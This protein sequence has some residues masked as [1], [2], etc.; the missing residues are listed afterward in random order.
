MIH[1]RTWL[2]MGTALAALGYMLVFEVDREVA[3]VDAPELLPGFSAAKVDAIEI[4]FQ[5]T[6]VLKIARDQTQWTLHEPIRYPAMAEGP[7]FLLNVIEHL[8][9]SGFVS[10]V[11]ENGLATYG[12]APPRAVLRFGLVETATPTELHLGSLTPLEDMVYARVPGQPG[13][14]LLPKDFQRAVPRLATF[15]RD[16]Y[17]IQLG[18]R[19]LDADTLSI[20]SGPRQ[21]VL[22]QNSTNATWVVAQ[23]APAKLGDKERIEQVL[24]NLWNWQ[25]VGFVSDDPKIDLEPFGLHSPVAEL[26]LGQ[27][28]NRLATL[29]FGNSPT[30]Q[31]GYVYARILNHTNVVIVPKPGLDDLR[32]DPWAFC[33]HRLA[34]PIA[35]SEL[36]RIE[37]AAADSFTLGQSTNGVWRL[38]APTSLPADQALV[39]DMLR[40]ILATKAAELKRELVADFS[41]FGLLEPTAQYTLRTRGGTNRI[42]TQL[43]FGANASPTGDKL[44]VRRAEIDSV[45]VVTSAMRQRLPS[46]SYKLRDRRYWSFQPNEVT[47]VTVVDGDKTTILQRNNAGKWTRP[48]RALT[49][50]EISQ[51]EIGIGMLGRFTVVDW[52]ARGQDKLAGYDILAEKKSLTLELLRGGQ[53]VSR[54]IQFGRNSPRQHVYAFATDPLEQEPVVFEFPGNAF[55]GCELGLFSLAMDPP[56][57][58]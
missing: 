16:P 56:P 30:N 49:G 3:P 27:G 20:R 45:Y 50:N 14:F 55:Q 46:Y 6:N 23:P 13:V 31:P 54:K 52:T 33:D 58:K 42:Q 12:L 17:L 2:L 21:L 28:T 10:G 29:Q 32:S 18:D 9:P 53:A 43:T 36:E 37:V 22:Q 19:R 48:G 15:W 26:T 40:N 47:K 7:A 44:Y 4:E 57:E 1:K 38:T 34:T 11:K 51:I 8:Q 24:V 35:P 25:V 41:E 39:M 5:G